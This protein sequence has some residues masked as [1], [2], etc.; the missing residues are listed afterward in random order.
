MKIGTYVT[1]GIIYRT[2]KNKK[3]WVLHALILYE[4]IMLIY[5]WNHKFWPKSE[6][7][8]PRIL[9][10]GVNILCRTHNNVLDEQYLVSE[11]NF[12]CIFTIY[13]EFLMYFFGFKTFVI[14]IFFGIMHHR[15][16][17]WSI[18]MLK[19]I[20][21]HPMNCV[22]NQIFMNK[23][24]KSG[25]TLTLYTKSRCW[26]IFGLTSMYKRFCSI[27]NGMY[28]FLRKWCHKMRETWK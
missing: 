2:I 17:D 4:L 12:L 11:I 20:D 26:A 22:N 1:C 7:K 19:W 14:V 28:N 5:V 27:L 6:N 15:T 13:H 9:I 16:F 3:N 25:F 18:I 23:V 8:A 21:L 24:R 10:F